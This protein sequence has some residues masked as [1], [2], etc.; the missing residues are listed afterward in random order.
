MANT[1]AGRFLISVGAE[2]GRTPE[3]MEPIIKRLVEDEWYDSIESLQR[4][5]DDQWSK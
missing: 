2:L 1:E 4:L 3:Q 5:T